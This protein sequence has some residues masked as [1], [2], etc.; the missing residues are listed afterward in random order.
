MIYKLKRRRAPLSW[1]GGK[2]G[3]LSRFIPLFP[4]HTTFVDVFG[5]GGA[6]TQC[7][8]HSHTEIYNDK[9]W[10]LANLFVVLKDDAA[11]DLLL[12]RCQKTVASLEQYLNCVA[13]TKRPTGEGDPLERAWAF[14]WSSQFTFSG[15]HPALGRPSRFTTKRYGAT[16]AASWRKHLDH[17][18]WRFRDV[19]VENADWADIVAKYD[20]AKTFFFVD[21]PYVLSTLSSKNPLYA[22]LMSDDEHL[23]LLYKLRCVAGKVMLC[24]YRSKL[25]DDHLNGWHRRQFERAV[26]L[27]S[28]KI[29]PR[30]NE[31]IWMNYDPRAR[32]EAVNARYGQLLERARADREAFHHQI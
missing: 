2:V 29:K 28:Q 16:Q 15:H 25:Y 22:H 6:V 26:C 1:P 19:V 8:P 24:G 13:I 4:N 14:Y 21:P 27:S 10:N 30:R 11:R 7:K 17:V 32:D 5:G 12:A 9:D 3:L 31:V 18:A 20:S 23:A